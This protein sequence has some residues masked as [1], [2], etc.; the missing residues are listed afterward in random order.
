M[1]PFEPKFEDYH[2]AAGPL[3]VLHVFLINING[4]K[5]VNI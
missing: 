4:L 2:S 3:V 5:N 1:Q